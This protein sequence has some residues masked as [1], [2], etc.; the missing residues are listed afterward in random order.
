[1]VTNLNLLLAEGG[2]AGVFHIFLPIGIQ[3][4]LEAFL[5]CF[6]KQLSYING[7]YTLNE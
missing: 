3:L 7:I 2:L 6:T 4:T 5:C 1:M